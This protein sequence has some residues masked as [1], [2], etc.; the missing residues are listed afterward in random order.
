MVCLFN[1]LTVKMVIMGEMRTQTHRIQGLLL[2]FFWSQW[3]Y[4]PFRVAPPELHVVMDVIHSL[5]F[6]WC[7]YGSAGLSLSS[8]ACMCAH[9]C[10][11][12]FKSLRPSPSYHQVVGLHCLQGSCQSYW[13]LWMMLPAWSRKNKQMWKRVG[14]KMGSGL[15]DN[16]VL[17][18]A[19][20]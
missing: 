9:V 7:P 18:I 19:S 8:V 6:S 5:Q 13:C 14:N 15:G 4:C 3:L 12:P 2:G 1:Y 17:H 10:L 20:V 11:G 16:A